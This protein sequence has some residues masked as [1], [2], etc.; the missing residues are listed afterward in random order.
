[1]SR[2]VTISPARS[3]IAAVMAGVCDGRPEAIGRLWELSMRPLRRQVR[4]AIEGAGFVATRDLVHDAAMDAFLR[5][6][7]RAPSWRADGGATPWHWASDMVRSVAFETLGIV[8]D[9]P[10]DHDGLAAVPSGPSAAEDEEPTIVLDR[11]AATMPD[12]AT[13]RDHLYRAAS[14]RD[15]VLHLRMAQERAAGNTRPAVTVAAELSMAPVAV[16]QAD[17]RVARRLGSAHQRVH[18]AAAA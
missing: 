9:D 5:L 2:P 12:V 15:R 6:I 17:S 3:E 16:R 13:Y 8:G 4:R 1:M 11:L 14:A 10:D 7:D 18:A